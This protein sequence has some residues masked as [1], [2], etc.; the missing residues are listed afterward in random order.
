MS[1]WREMAAYQQAIKNVTRSLLV[2][3]TN[4]TSAQILLQSSRQPVRLSALEQVLSLKINEFNLYGGDT[5]D[6]HRVVIRR[7]QMRDANGEWAIIGNNTY[8]LGQNGQWHR[9]HKR[10][11]FASPEKALKCWETSDAKQELEEEGFMSWSE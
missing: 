4:D 2:S 11:R 10:H 7:M 3:L 8:E 6:P 9:D 5:Y 1:H